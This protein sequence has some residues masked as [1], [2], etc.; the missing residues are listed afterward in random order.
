MTLRRL[1]HLY[2][3]VDGTMQPKTV[4]SG[5]PLPVDHPRHPLLLA[6]VAPAAACSVEAAT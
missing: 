2:Q 6:T 4:L 3:H 5:V 1:S